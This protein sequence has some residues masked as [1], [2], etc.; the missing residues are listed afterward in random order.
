MEEDSRRRGQNRD[1]AL[2][3]L[4]RVRGQYIG[5]RAYYAHIKDPKPDSGLMRE[6]LPVP[7]ELT[8]AGLGWT[9]ECFCP[10]NSSAASGRVKILVLIL[11]LGRTQ[12]GG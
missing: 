9:A 10:R 2:W 3:T 4:A 1:S 5:S 8:H 6:V 11:L 7:G 12:P